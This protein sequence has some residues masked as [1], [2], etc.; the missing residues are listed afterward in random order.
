MITGLLKNMG[1]TPPLRVSS[2]S[3][4]FK[5]CIGVGSQVIFG[6]KGDAPVLCMLAWACSCQPRAFATCR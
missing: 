3:E 5:T 1:F 6:C 4:E 2:N